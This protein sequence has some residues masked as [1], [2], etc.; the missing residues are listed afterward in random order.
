VVE[1]RAVTVETPGTDSV[2]AR[3]ATRLQEGWGDQFSELT[4]G[5]PMAG[6]LP[7]HC[8]DDL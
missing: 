2:K 6:Q 4:A 1:A 7:L 8:S 3:K 5:C